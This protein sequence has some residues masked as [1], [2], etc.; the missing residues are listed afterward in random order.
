MKKQAYEKYENGTRRGNVPSRP[1][2]RRE[3]RSARALSWAMTVGLFS[4]VSVLV[5]GG[6]IS[7]A[8]NELSGEYWLSDLSGKIKISEGG[9]EGTLI[10]FGEVLGMEESQEI[11]GAR[12][13]LQLGSRN[14]VTVGFFQTEHKGEKDLS[15]G[16]WFAGDFYQVDDRVRSE[17]ETTFIQGWYER[18]LLGQETGRLSLILGGEYVAMKAR[19]SSGIVGSASKS[20]KASTPIAGL[21]LEM[22]PTKQLEFRAELVGAI[23]DLSDVEITTWDGRAIIGYRFHPNLKLQAVYRFLGIEAA[24]AEGNEG[25]LSLQGPALS[26]VLVF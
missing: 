23:I 18:V 25:D 22:R 16:V 9:I 21:A 4:L 7:L 13:T 2:P 15:E 3:L 26:L 1:N 19:L 24:E 11:L 12:G 5:L 14:R 10:D 8:D 20:V 6:E 17:L